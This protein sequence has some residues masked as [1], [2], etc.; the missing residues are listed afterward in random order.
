[1]KK[2]LF[3]LFAA[4]GLAFLTVVGCSNS[5]IDTAKVRTALQSIEPGQKELLEQALTAID[6]GKYKDAY[7]PLRKIALGAKLNAEQNNILKDTMAKV[8]AK[9]AKGP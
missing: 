5:N 4:T 6:A 2:R 8:E 9:I 1:M 3:T 7:P